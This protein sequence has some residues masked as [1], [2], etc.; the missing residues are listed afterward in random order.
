MD[1]TMMTVWIVIAV[2]GIALDVLSS[3]FFFIWFT[4]S[5]IVAII[6]MLFGLSTAAQIILFIILSTVLIAVAYPLVKD[7]IKKTVKVTKTQEQEYIGRV[8]V[9]EKD[10]ET[11]ETVKIEGIYWTVLNEGEVIK[12]GDKF[13]ILELRGTK[14]LVAI[15][16]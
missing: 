4:L 9:A 7:A 8:Y 13:K 5:A 12:Q 14:F 1:W 15:E 3:N 2:A 11:K 6:A 10:I 16:K